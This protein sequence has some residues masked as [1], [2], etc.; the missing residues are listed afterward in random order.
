MKPRD[1]REGDVFD[2]VV[3]LNGET[4]RNRW[5]AVSDSWES[6]RFP[7]VYYAVTRDVETGKKFENVFSEHFGSQ[8]RRVEE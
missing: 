4:I 7:G 5:R 1:I 6:D 2:E 8:L 3:T